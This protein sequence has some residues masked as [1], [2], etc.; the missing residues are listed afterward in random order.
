MLYIN[1]NR[2][3]YK[4]SNVLFLN[5]ISSSSLKSKGWIF[6]RDASYYRTFQEPAYLTL[7]PIPRAGACLPHIVSYTKGRSLPTSHCI[8]Y[9][10]QGQNHPYCQGGL[11]EDKARFCPL[12]SA[13]GASPRP[14]RY[15]QQDRAKCAT[16]VLGNKPGGVGGRSREQAGKEVS[17]WHR[18]IPVEERQR[19]MDIN[20]PE[21]QALSTGSDKTKVLAHPQVCCQGTHLSQDQVW[22]S[23][24]GTPYTQYS[25]DVGRW[26]K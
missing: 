11:W 26:K 1:E 15:R 5:I 23:N 2:D 16:P 4:H 24:P 20:V 12:T 10:G 13:S 19:R 14:L 17:P 21:H 9:Q 6:S 25:H 22:L 7:Y 3:S 18:A 8:L